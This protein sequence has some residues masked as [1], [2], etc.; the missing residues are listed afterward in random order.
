MKKYFFALLSLPV[1]IWTACT[2]PSNA[3]QPVSGLDA[4][5][6]AGDQRFYDV[7]TGDLPCTECD[8]VVTKLWLYHAADDSLGQYR[9]QETRVGGTAGDAQPVEYRGTFNIEQGNAGTDGLL[10]YRLQSN[11]GQPFRVFLKKDETTLVAM[12]GNS[13][14]GSSDTRFVLSKIGQELMADSVTVQ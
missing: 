4:P 13:S 7:Y 10:V 6:K 2:N 11:Q 5:A 9:L 3:P 1:A 12:H 8:K 14:P